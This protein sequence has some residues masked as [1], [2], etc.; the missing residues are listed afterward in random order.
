M[1]NELKGGSG[2]GSHFTSIDVLLRILVICHA[3][4]G[5]FSINTEELTSHSNASEL[6]AGLN[7]ACM[8]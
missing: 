4:L 6:D 3:E 5:N 2:I 1:F 8:A 7:Y